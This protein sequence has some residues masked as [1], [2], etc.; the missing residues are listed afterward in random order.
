MATTRRTALPDFLPIRRILVDGVVQPFVT[1]I[2]FDSAALDVD[3]DESAGVATISRTEVASETASSTS[4]LVFDRNKIIQVDTYLGKAFLGPATSG[5]KVGATIM[6]N[7]AAD[8]L[9]SA[10]NLILASDFDPDGELALA[11][12]HTEWQSIILTCVEATGRGRFTASLR[13][14]PQTTTTPVL[15]SAVLDGS[16]PDKLVLTFEDGSGNPLPMLL[17]DLTGISLSFGVGTART[18]TAIDSVNADASEW[19]LDLSGDV[20]EGDAFSLVIGSTRTWRSMN[21]TQ[22]AAGTTA[23]TVQGFAYDYDSTT[24]LTFH[25]DPA[26]DQDSGGN[27]NPIGSWTSQV[28]TMAWTAS[29]TA[30]P[31]YVANKGGIPAAYFNGTANVLTST[32]TIAD[33]F[34]ATTGYFA[35]LVW[36]EAIDG[37]ANNATAYLNVGI[38]SD[39]TGY[40]GLFIKTVPEVRGYI[41]DG[42]VESGN[43]NAAI[44]TGAWH[45]VTLRWEGGN[46]YV[47]VDGVESSAEPLAA[48]IT[49]LTDTLKLGRGPGSG[50]L[51]QG[52]IG[53]HL[54]CDTVPGGVERAAIEAA[55]MAEAG[56]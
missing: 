32:S 25:F 47:G 30:R 54:G 48:G 46:M 38:L 41:F 12:D 26:L 7:V 29:T 36:I 22:V 17:P 31:T 9:S 39:A 45:L 21:G 24:G 40:M 14:A 35:A 15:V 51:F 10:A 37:A 55:M 23:V 2:D 49:T 20:A 42:S 33:M 18:I 52:W 3:V 4:A 53:R 50:L 13:S 5:H 56:I 1:D 34:N 16:D 44:A 6:A 43:A 19:T 8:E 11:F 27:G 28:G